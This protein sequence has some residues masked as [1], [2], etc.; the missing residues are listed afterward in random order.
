LEFHHRD[1]KFSA[2]RGCFRG[3]LRSERQEGGTPRKRGAAGGGRPQKALQMLA[4]ARPFSGGSYLTIETREV[5]CSPSFESNAKELEREML[6]RSGLTKTVAQSSVQLDWSATYGQAP[7]RVAARIASSMHSDFQTWR[8]LHYHQRSVIER[9]HPAAPDGASWFISLYKVRDFL[10]KLYG[11][12]AAAK[13]AL[14]ISSSQWKDFGNLLNNNDLRHAEISGTSPPISLE[15]QEKLYRMA[16]H[17]VASYLCTKGITGHWLM[18][19]SQD[20]IP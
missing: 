15:D 18:E 16:L 9:S 7:L 11:N 12:D 4:A 20:R 1:G 13:R 14:D 17:W 5:A 10:S 2:R 3:Q 6:A 8:L 19:T